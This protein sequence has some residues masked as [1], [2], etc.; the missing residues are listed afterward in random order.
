V[1]RQLVDAVGI[2]TQGCGTARDEPGLRVR[3]PAG[4]KC[5]VVTKLDKLFREIRNNALRATIKLGRDAF[6]E[7]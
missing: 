5:D 3:V 7:G 6:V 1:V 4:E 2:Q